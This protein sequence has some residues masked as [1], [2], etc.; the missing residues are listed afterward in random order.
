MNK[1]LNIGNDKLVLLSWE[2]LSNKNE[3]IIAINDC[4]IIL[5]LPDNPL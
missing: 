2:N 5:I 4:N 1:F 3:N